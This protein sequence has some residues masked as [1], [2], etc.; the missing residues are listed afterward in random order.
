MNPFKGRATSTGEGG[1]GEVPEIPAPDTYFGVL[2]A[3]IDLGTQPGSAKFPDPKRQCLLVW[4]ITEDGVKNS[5]GQ[6]FLLR[7]WMTLSYHEK[8]SLRQMLETW[9]RKP[10]MD[11]EDIDIA[12]YLGQPWT[13]EVSHSAPSEKGHVY[14][15]VDKA[16][17][18]KKGTAVPPSTIKPV[19][20]FIGGPDPIPEYPW[21]PRVYGKLA[22]ELIEESPEWKALRRPAPARTHGG[23]VLGDAADSF[24]QAAGKGTEEDIPF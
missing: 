20:W 21:L 19:C 14:A 17:P 24:P 12:R 6:P 11:G 3:I 18:V 15:Q 4:E 7:R 16:G 22:K 5:R 1:G 2:V 13:L 8:G 9:R 23:M 10:Y